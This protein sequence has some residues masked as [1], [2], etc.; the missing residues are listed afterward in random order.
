VVFL[1]DGEQ[2][3]LTASGQEKKNK[4]DGRRYL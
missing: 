1:L 3:A 2:K 4:R